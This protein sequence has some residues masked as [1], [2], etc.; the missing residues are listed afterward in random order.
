MEKI[1]HQLIGGLS[2]SIFLLIF[3]RFRPSKVVQDFLGFL[4]STVSS[5]T[6][7]SSHH[8]SV[9]HQ[10]F[11]GGKQLVAPLRMLQLP[12]PHLHLAKALWPLRGLAPGPARPRY[13]ALWAYTSHKCTCKVICQITNLAC[14]NIQLLSI[15][16]LSVCLSICLSNSIYLSICLSIYLSIYPSIYLSIVHMCIYIYRVHK[17][18]RQ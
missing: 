5:T 15:Y 6:V 3:L 13:H 18:H 7:P 16:Y 10:R 8:T 4:P 9:T 11:P 14:M 2:L 1:Q 12:G 17:H